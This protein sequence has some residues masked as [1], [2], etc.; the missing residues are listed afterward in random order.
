MSSF[1]PLCPLRTRSSCSTTSLYIR[2]VGHGFYGGL[3]VLTDIFPVLPQDCVAACVKDNGKERITVMNFVY[4]CRTVSTL[5]VQLLAIETSFFFA[6]IGSKIYG[7][8]RIVKVTTTGECG[9]MRVAMCAYD[10]L[11]AAPCAGVLVF[12]IRVTVN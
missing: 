4:S 5:D 7:G 10:F 11:S 2:Q 12:T 8:L 1:T 9:A 6:F 3:R